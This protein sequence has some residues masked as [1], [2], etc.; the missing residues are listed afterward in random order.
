MT[1][2]ERIRRRAREIYEERRS[3]GS[4][5]DAVTDWLAAEEEIEAA[6]M[7]SPPDEDND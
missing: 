1:R 5:G 4:P 7:H 2:E 3:K 6:E